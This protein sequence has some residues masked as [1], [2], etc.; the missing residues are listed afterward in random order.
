[1]SYSTISEEYEKAKPQ[2]QVTRAL[3]EFPLIE[4][5]GPPAR[6]LIPYEKSGPS[7]TVH[8]LTRVKARIPD[9]NQ[10][11]VYSSE[12]YD[13]SSKIAY[14]FVC[15]NPSN[16]HPQFGHIKELYHHLFCEYESI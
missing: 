13:K 7:L 3:S 1:M 11:I 8:S 4:H 2:S 15:I 14:L 9:T 5:W 10:T 6:T 12:S 16:N